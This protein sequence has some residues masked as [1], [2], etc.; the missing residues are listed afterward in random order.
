MR[1]DGMTCLPLCG[2]LCSELSVGFLEYV[3]AHPLQGSRGAA[4]LPAAGA[5]GQG[6]V[7]E[8][9]PE[10]LPDGGGASG[11]PL[12][13]GVSGW[14]CARLAAARHALSENRLLAGDGQVRPGEWERNAERERCDPSG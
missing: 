12:P 11:G 2:L 10:P 1:C 6:G 4:E 9:R 3:S 13:R 8:A 7:E 5:R 14:R